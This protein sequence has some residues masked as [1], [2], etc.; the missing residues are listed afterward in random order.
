ML[1]FLKT[2]FSP[3]LQQHTPSVQQL[4]AISE[5]LFRQGD[6]NHIQHNMIEGIVHLHTMKV[7]DVMIP[8]ARIQALDMQSSLQD[9][10]S[11]IATHRHSRYPVYDGELDRIKGVF[12]AKDLIT[13]SGISP[14]A[15]IATCMRPIITTPE[16]K[17]LDT[18]LTD[19]QTSHSHMAIV[20][21]EYGGVSGLITIEDVIEQ[22]TGTIED[23]HDD[24]K[25]QK[26]LIRELDPQRF[27]VDALTP[28]DVFNQA[29]DCA[30]DDTYFD[31]IGGII[32]QR[33]GKIAEKGDSCA[34]DDF[35]VT[36][37]QA[38]PTHIKLVEIRKK[39]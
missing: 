24:T 23:E 27:I 39:T 8:R 10:I 21:D 16:S 1:G 11:V 20:V 35:V 37:L 17:S 32:S 13:E 14:T 26:H 19:F 4:L 36:V 6:I 3:K 38:S 34:L 5:A 12:L 29:F 25:D 31:T 28:I 15:S 7:R 30:Y 18:I 33:F 22:A 9:A 2:Y